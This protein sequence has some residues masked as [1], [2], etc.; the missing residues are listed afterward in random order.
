M[1]YIFPIIALCLTTGSFSLAH[2][3]IL[4]VTPAASHIAVGESIALTVE[5]MMVTDLYAYQFDVAFDPAKVQALA[6][7]PGTF[8]S[9]G[10]G[11]IPGVVNNIA[12]TIQ[13]TADTL[14]GTVPGVSGSGTLATFQ[15]LAVATGMSPIAVTN[16]IA[17]DSGLNDITLSV[18]SGSVTIS[19]VPEPATST[20]LTVG[21][22]ASLFVRKRLRVTL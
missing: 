21:L 7:T 16:V 10:S 14:W 17:L 3:A 6:I 22:T 20:L 15:F 9:A 19:A 12:G 18:E 1:N 11:F 5:A 4:R 13:F 2:A 8:V